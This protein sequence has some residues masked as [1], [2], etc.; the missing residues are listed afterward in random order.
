MR[1]FSFFLTLFLSFNIFAATSAQVV[2]SASPILVG[3]FS[4][5]NKASFSQ[6][7]KPLFEKQTRN[8]G[9]CQIV[10]LTPYDDKGEFNLAALEQSLKEIPENVKILFFNFN[11]KRSDIPPGVVE[12]LAQIANSGSL[13]VASAGAPKENQA[14]GPLSKTLFGQIKDTL[15]I[16][17]LGERDRLMPQGFFGPEM[18]TAVRAPKEFQGQGVGPLLFASKLAANYHRKTPQE[19]TDY[20]KSKKSKSRRIWPEL[21][22]FFN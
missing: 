15:I 3:Y 13:V 19:W 16:G 22:D 20:L 8:C 5:D 12:R 7:I 21:E 14:S 2:G 18:L 10:D 17:E 9:S 1:T 4:S 6:K 11:L